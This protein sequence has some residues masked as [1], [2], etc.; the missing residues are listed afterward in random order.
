MDM[1]AKTIAQIRQESFQKRNT[2][3]EIAYLL[4][5]KFQNKFKNDFKT[6]DKSKNAEV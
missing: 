5:W 6:N 2:V 1:F 3:F 4:A